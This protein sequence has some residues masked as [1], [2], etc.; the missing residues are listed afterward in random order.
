MSK[1]EEDPK[2]F[3][4][5]YVI[6]SYLLYDMPN[7][8]VKARIQATEETIDMLNK[9]AWMRDKGWVYLPEDQCKF[10]FE[11]EKRV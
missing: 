1:K 7:R 10:T 8:K 2:T 3:P 4:H 6:I 5:S 11:G 9:P